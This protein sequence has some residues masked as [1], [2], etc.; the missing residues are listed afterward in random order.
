MWRQL[1]AG[2]LTVPASP[3]FAQPEGDDAGH[4]VEL[5]R[6][7]QAQ[8]DRPENDAV[9]ALPSRPVACLPLSM[10]PLAASLGPI[11]KC[12]PGSGTSAAE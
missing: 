8:A 9:G 12:L 5:G 6:I 4:D 11:F 7:G 2:W 10:T 1:V 3:S